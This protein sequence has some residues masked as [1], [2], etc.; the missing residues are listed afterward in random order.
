MGL[1]GIGAP[2][3][4]AVLLESVTVAL[5]I[6]RNLIMRCLQNPFDEVMASVVR[7]RG[8]GGISILGAFIADIRGNRI[9]TNGLDHVQPVCG[10]FLEMGSQIEI[11]DNEISN[12][13]P[14]D[15]DRTEPVAL[16]LRGGVVLSLLV[17]VTFRDTNADG[18]FEV[19]RGASSPA[20]R[21]HDNLVVQPVGRALFLPGVVGVLSICNNRFTTKRPDLLVDAVTPV[22][23]IHVLNIGSEEIGLLSGMTLFNDNQ[24]RLESVLGGSGPFGAPAS[25]QI[26]SLD[27]IC[28]DANQS[29]VVDPRAASAAFLSNTILF[30][31]TLRATSSRFREILGQTLA[32]SLITGGGVNNTSANQGDHCIFVVGPANATIP[33][34]IDFNQVIDRTL[35]APFVGIVNDTQTDFSYGFG[36]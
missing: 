13:G 1:S 10:I 20:A 25:I 28:F 2:Y 22:G 21:V 6:H 5:S 32:S 18:T 29:V 9:E 26:I 16:G 23:C 17:S 24:I 31:R 4:A 8:M 12:N 19:I 11:H 14:I 35:C 7:S 15:V 30:A 3:P 34:P 36:F 33:T 27:D